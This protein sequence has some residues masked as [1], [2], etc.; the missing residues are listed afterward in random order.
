[1]NSDLSY[2][3][4]SIHLTDEKTEAHSRGTMDWG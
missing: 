4:I 1:M 2:F 3:P